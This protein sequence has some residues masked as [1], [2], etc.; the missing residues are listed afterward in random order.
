MKSGVSP[1]TCRCPAI[2][3]TF[4]QLERNNHVEKIKYFEV[5]FSRVCL[6]DTAIE[7]DRERRREHERGR[8]SGISFYS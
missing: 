1:V 3:M 2:K 4:S 5:I 7:R 6:C 8:E